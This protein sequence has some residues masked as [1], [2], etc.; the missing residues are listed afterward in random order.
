MSFQAMSWAAEQNCPSS[1]SKLVLL[2]L[3]NYA[4]DRHQ[5]YPSYKKLAELCACNERT[6]M[7]AINQLK[8]LNLLTV[9]KRY[10]EDGKQTS[11]TFTL[12]VSD[13]KD[14]V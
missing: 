7:R 9:T 12:Y 1:V 4:N 3:A 5:T 13:K 14:R 11:N 8:E 10:G 2:M 6:V